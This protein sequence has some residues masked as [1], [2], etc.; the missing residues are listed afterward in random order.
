MMDTT[1][2]IGQRLRVRKL[3]QERM[4]RR[5]RPSSC[6]YVDLDDTDSESGTESENHMMKG[7]K[8]LEGGRRSHEKMRGT[9]RPS[10]SKSVDLDEKT[11]NE[12]APEGE[13]GMT[14][15]KDLKRRGGFSTSHGVTKNH[16]RRSHKKMRYGNVFLHFY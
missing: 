6:K 5:G 11:E 15:Q 8:G 7:Q 16:A 9:G 4:R 10:S 1:P 12:S 3:F 2:S 13:D 14:K